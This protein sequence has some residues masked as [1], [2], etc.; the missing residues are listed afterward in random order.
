MIKVDNVVKYYGE[1]LALKGVSYT[2]NKGEIVGFLGP[3]GAGKSTMMR[4][5]TGYLPATSGY[6]YLDDYEVYDNPIELKKRIGYMPENVSLYTEMTVTDYLKFCA[7]LKGVPSKKVKS[8]VENT[9]EITGLTKYK[10]R[11]IGHLS[12]GY[13]QRT[14]IAQAIIHDPEVLILDEPTSGLDPNQLIEVRALIK[15]LGGT[16]TV[17]LSTHILSEV[18]DTCERALIIDSGELIAEDTIEGLKMAMDREILGGNIELKVADRQ[19]DA[20]LCVREVNGVVQAETDNFGTIIIECERGNDSRAEIVKHL[21]NNNFDVLEIKP[22]E[23]SLE[24]VFIYFTDKKKNQDFDKSKYIKDDSI[25]NN[26][27]E[28]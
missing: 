2:I 19:N 5:I 7:K 12:K 22:K 14:G 10:D 26:T 3:N 1:H 4:I 28:E 6:V 20:L 23:R 17:I 11:I 18:E 27:E 25:K 8:A 9:I 16:R 13:R 21:V 15:S 24:E